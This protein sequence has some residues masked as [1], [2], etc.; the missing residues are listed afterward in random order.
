MESGSATGR[1]VV[2]TTSLTA[3]QG[4]LI[5][6]DSANDQLG[7]SVS[8]AGDIDG[9][10]IDDLI[11]GA[12]AGE[13][14]GGTADTGSAYVLYGRADRAFGVNTK[15]NASGNNIKESATAYAGLSSL[16]ARLYLSLI[17]P[18]LRLPMLALLLRVWARE[19]TISSR[20]PARPAGL[21]EASNIITAAAG[22]DTLKFTEADGSRC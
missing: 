10:G 20:S 6:G 17:L 14:A 5:Q 2:D 19:R 18:S 4:F 8:G 22:I 12:R 11:I 15:A 1:R 13:I 16:C 9:D 3:E 21:A 7:V